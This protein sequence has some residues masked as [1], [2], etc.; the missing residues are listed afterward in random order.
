MT[1]RYI[2]TLLHLYISVLL[3]L[4][5]RTQVIPWRNRL[6][7][8]TWRTIHQNTIVC[9]NRCCCFGTLDLIQYRE[10][11]VRI[12]SHDSLTRWYNTALL[13]FQIAV[14]LPFRSRSQPSL[15]VSF[16]SG[17]YYPQSMKVRWC[18]CMRM[19]EG[20]CACILVCVCIVCVLVTQTT[21]A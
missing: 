10:V 6:S 5:S 9:S 4:C 11:I 17:S 18:A 13:Y 21:Y 20:L 15:S 7:N 19:D 16:C 8:L 12:I 2:A 14:L 3:S 1:H